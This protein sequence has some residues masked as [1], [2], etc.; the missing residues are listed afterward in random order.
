MDK[1]YAYYHQSLNNLRGLDKSCVEIGIE[2]KKIGRV[3]N[4]RWLASSFRT[5]KAVWNNYPVIYLHV[6]K[7]HDAISNGIRSKLE[8]SFF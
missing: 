8:S 4:V 6:S 7:E 1:L 5:I 2:M 3:L